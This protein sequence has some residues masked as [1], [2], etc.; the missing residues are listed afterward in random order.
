LTTHKA[1]ILTLFIHLFIY[2]GFIAPI[3]IRYTCGIKSFQQPIYNSI[4]SI[5]HVC[6][7]ETCKGISS[8]K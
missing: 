7:C 5:I 2:L 4:T 1:H 3:F 8:V 6:A